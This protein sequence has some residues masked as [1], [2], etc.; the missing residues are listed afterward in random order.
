[1]DVGQ[2]AVAADAGAVIPGLSLLWAPATSVRRTRPSAYPGRG[3][4]ATRGDLVRPLAQTYRGRELPAPVPDWVQ[5]WQ[6]GE[7][8]SGSRGG[9]DDFVLP[10]VAPS[11]PTFRIAAIH[12][13]RRTESLV[14]TSPL[15]VPA[16]ALRA[17]YLAPWPVGQLPLASK[18]LIGAARPL[19]S[20]PQMCQR[21]PELALVAGAVL[22]YAVATQPAVPTGFWD[23]RPRPTTGRLRRVL[24]RAESPPDSALPARIRA[25]A[26][27]TDHLPK[28]FWGQRPRTKPA[29]PP[30][31]RRGRSTTPADAA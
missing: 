7:A 21:L 9:M 22:T 29:P 16:R 31:Q 18:Q 19:V 5:P 12:D 24:S 14:L 10:E 30:Q 6:G 27:V 26:A 2:R 23:C 25:R 20:A 1:M 15:A 4:P 17:L 8:G 13:P 28:G 3:R 11:A